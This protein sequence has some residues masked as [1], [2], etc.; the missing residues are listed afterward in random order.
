MVYI[1]DDHDTEH[2]HSIKHVQV[3]L[4]C[5]D[6]SLETLNVCHAT[7]YRSYHDQR[8]GYVQRP[9]VLSPNA[10]VGVRTCSWHA[11]KS[12]VEDNGHNEEECEEDE[13]HE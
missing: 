4:M 3:H 5:I 7:D 11:A 10:V 13:L 2:Q 9:E 1:E 8:T 12:D 6:I